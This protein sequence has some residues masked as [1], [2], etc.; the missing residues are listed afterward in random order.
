MTRF[1]KE[2]RSIWSTLYSLFRFSNGRN[3][4]TSGFFFS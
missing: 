1:S 2:I 4:L 3:G